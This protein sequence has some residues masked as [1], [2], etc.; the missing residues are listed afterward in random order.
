MKFK[1]LTKAMAV[2][3]FAFCANMANAQL[4]EI[5]T[6]AAYEPFEY[7]DENDNFV[8]FDID[9]VNAIA[10]VQGFQVE[11]V[12]LP[13][14]ILL[15][16]LKA[17]ELD[18]VISSLSITSERQAIYDFSKP[19]FKAG[20][21]ILVKSNS[22]FTSINDLRNKRI[23]AQ[24]GTTSYEAASKITN[25]IV[26][27]SFREQSLDF[28]RT[29]KCEALADDLPINLYYLSTNNI[30]DLKNLGNLEAEYY[31]IAV[32]KGN[33]ATLKLINDGLS[34]LEASGKLHELK[35]KWFGNSVED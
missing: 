27:T 26:E 9:L 28:L 4:L 13:F 21:S 32:T 33:D 12:N 19:Y 20:I 11:F 22:G 17:D 7:I 30:T 25:N 14:D 3:G 8:G 24:S 29:N 35:V 34:K 15:T 1:P 16:S 23:C 31:G 18:A 10:E 6:E 5:G 2:L